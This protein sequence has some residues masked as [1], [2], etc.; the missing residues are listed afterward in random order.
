MDQLSREQVEMQTMLCQGPHS[1]QVRVGAA[2]LIL[3]N[4]AAQRA[5][6]AALE[7]EL[8]IARSQQDLSSTI[9]AEY[10]AQ[11]EAMNQERVSACGEL[12]VSLDDAPVGSLAGKLVTANRVLRA[13]L[14]T[15]TAENNRLREDAA[16]DKESFYRRVAHEIDRAMERVKVRSVIA[17]GEAYDE[18]L[19]I[20]DSYDGVIIVR[21]TSAALR[22]EGG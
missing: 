9:A 6:I 19:Q 1:T 16:K 13:K 5:R 8:R 20:V 12:L 14:A 11:L 21:M 4:D 17:R 3:A 22:G 18:Q 10:K 15:M 7:Q 2:S